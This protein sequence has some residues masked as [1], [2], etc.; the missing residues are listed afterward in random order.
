[1]THLG[2]QLSAL[3]DGQLTPAAAERALAH[4]AGCQQCAADL[5]AA[6]NARA[7]LAAAFEVRPDPDL[8][9]RLLALG[10]VPPAP[11]PGSE[12]V[13]RPREPRPDPFAGSPLLP[14]AGGLPSGALRGDVE[15][16]R[17][18]TG[19]VL[20]VG[21]GLSLVAALFVTGT[22]P[23][24]APEDHPGV[25]L[26]VLGRAAAAADST[27][28]ATV[29]T[30]LLTHGATSPATARELDG[31]LD[32]HPWATEVSVPQDHVV[33][34]VRGGDDV[35]EVDLVGPRGLVVITQTRGRLAPEVGEPLV[36]AGREVRLLSR[37]P[38]QAAWQ[39]GDV[40]VTVVAEVPS[41]AATGVVEAYPVEPYDD[42]APARVRRGWEAFVA[43]WSGQ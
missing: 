20:V 1:M 36:V 15:R 10:A 25:A 11:A 34:A 12:Q 5:R 6:R 42:G 28:A 32:S 3:A 8:T 18:G 27:T 13:R 2:S 35:L 24:V 39:C 4:V 33:A 19:P 37:S 29:S 31:W 21:A 26:S 22:E 38:W 43:A 23:T 9:T 17:L 40:V 41:G 14:G 7:A 16:R 30:A